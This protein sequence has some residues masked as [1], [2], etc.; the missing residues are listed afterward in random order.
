MQEHTVVYLK[1]FIKGAYVLLKFKWCI[2]RAA[3]ENYQGKISKFVV[4]EKLIMIFK[5]SEVMFGGHLSSRMDG[6]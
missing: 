3:L 4:T 6:L 1:A 2:K 5:Y